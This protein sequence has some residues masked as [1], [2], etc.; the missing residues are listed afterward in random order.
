[1]A[2]PSPFSGDTLA[3][4]YEGAFAMT[5]QPSTVLS[6]ER[7]RCDYVVYGDPSNPAHVE[8]AQGF[9]EDHLRQHDDPDGWKADHAP[10]DEEDSE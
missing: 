4:T 9:Y 5:N 10:A 2:R 6:C 8:Q 7:E 3:K 1:M